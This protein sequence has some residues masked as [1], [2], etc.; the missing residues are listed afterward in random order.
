MLW[1]ECS[2][3]ARSRQGQGCSLAACLHSNQQTGHR[4]CTMTD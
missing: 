1:S 4:V 2:F 3:G